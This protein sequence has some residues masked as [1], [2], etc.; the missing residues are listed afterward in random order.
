MDAYDESEVRVLR[1][2]VR[3]APR[4]GSA[5][6]VDP[7]IAPARR[8]RENAGEGD[9]VATDPAADLKHRCVC[10]DADMP[11]QI[12][13]VALRDIVETIGPCTGDVHQVNRDLVAGIIEKCYLV[14]VYA[15]PRKKPDDP[16]AHKCES[17]LC[18]WRRAE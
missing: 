2:D 10:W 9:R 4:D 3:S 18:A 15:P 8:Y 7:G 11:A 6:D 14:L 16:C 5:D 13:H 1:R 12:R 17:R